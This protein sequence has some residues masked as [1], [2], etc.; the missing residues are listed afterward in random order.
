M[1]TRTLFLLLVAAL[2]ALFTILNWQA[3]T[4][5]TTLWLLFAR[6]QAPLGLVMLGICGLLTV[7]FLLYV[8]YV[9]TTAI[10]EAR[11]YARELQAQ[12]QVADGAEASR[13]AELRGVVD[14][15]V[16]S[17]EERITQSQSAAQSALGQL[18]IEL[19]AAIEQS[20]TIL[21]SY[22]GEMEDRLEHQLASAKPA[23]T[24]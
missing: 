24:P 19:R 4:T 6:V 3:F 16:R 22:I 2:L 9:Q 18:A 15:G 23:Q 13:I 7:L 11:R 17:L 14:A 12:R 1:S 10:L 5:S 8:A 21:T 20:G